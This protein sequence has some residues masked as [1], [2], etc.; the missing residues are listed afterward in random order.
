MMGTGKLRDPKVMSWIESEEVL[1]ICILSS[2]GASGVEITVTGSETVV[3]MVKL[4]S[5]SE[6]RVLR[7]L[8]LVVAGDASALT[9]V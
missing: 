1:A 3:P 6:V 5:A 8:I 9:P 4:L 2:L 7:K